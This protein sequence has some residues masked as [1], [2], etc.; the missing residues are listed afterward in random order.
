MAF[1]PPAASRRQIAGVPFD[2]AVDFAPDA[3]RRYDQ[4]DRR[5]NNH[6][7][8]KCKALLAFPGNGSEVRAVFWSA[9]MAIDTDGPAAGRGRKTG[10]QLDPTGQNQTSFRFTDGKSLPAEIVPYI[11]V[12]QN[13]AENGPFDPAVAMGDVAIVI[14][15]DM[16]TAAICGDFGPVKKIGEAS[17]RVHESLQPACPD[18]CKRDANGFCSKAKNASVEQDVLY[19]VFPGSKFAPGELDLDNIVTKV[20]ERAFTLYNQLRGAS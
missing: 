18:P 15:K 10:K 6:D 14:F 11:V 1:R 16:I 7:P 3:K 19:F 8:S 12:P 2:T 20:K 13:E 4:F 5:P 9:K 17:I